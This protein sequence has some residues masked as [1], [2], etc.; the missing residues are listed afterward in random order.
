MPSNKNFGYSFVFIFFVASAIFFYFNKNSI[1][2]ILLFFC[3]TFLIIT[4]IK[5]DLLGSFNYLWNRFAL[6]LNRVISPIIIF[7]IFF[8]II[9][10]Y[11]IVARL[12]SQDLKKISGKFDNKSISNFVDYDKKT[13]YEKQF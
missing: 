3:I 2:L 11:G 6:L 1:S 13:N 4:I 5:P 7:I 10:P 8:F 9:T 12:F